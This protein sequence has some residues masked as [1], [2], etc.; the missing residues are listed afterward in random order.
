MY[1]DDQEAFFAVRSEKPPNVFSAVAIRQF[2]EE[3]LHLRVSYPRNCS[4]FRALGG[5]RFPVS[6]VI[7]RS[8]NITPPPHM[9]PLPHLEPYETLSSI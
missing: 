7:V 2:M 9:Y 1:A 8:Y 5:V 6:T 4:S 3:I